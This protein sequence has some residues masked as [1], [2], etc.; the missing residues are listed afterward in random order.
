MKRALF[1][2]A[3]VVSLPLCMATV[4]LWVRS[5]RYEV[6]HASHAGAIRVYRAEGLTAARRH[7]FFV[8]STVGRVYLSYY[9]QWRGDGRS[10]LNLS[11]PSTPFA[12]RFTLSSRVDWLPGA[13]WTSLDGAPRMFG[14]GSIY[15][16]TKS[17][18]PHWIAEERGT[19]IWFPHAIA[20]LM[21]AILPIT[22]GS[23][24]ILRATRH[25]RR[26]SEG[27]CPLCNYDLRATPERC[28]E[29]GTIP[30]RPIAGTQA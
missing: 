29:C 25:R 27:N 5:W 21:F 9:Q 24:A 4:A 17:W 3:V 20:V 8:M 10:E 19:C 1:N 13:V 12:E 23:V 16:F 22:R 11:G 2:L 6:A 18:Q 14:I 30:Q 7:R 15:T 28:P 26:R